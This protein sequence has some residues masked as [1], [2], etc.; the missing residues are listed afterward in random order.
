MATGLPEAEIARRLGAMVPTETP[1]VPG[2]VIL[3]PGQLLYSHEYN[4]AMTQVTWM[5][6]DKPSA[7]SDFYKVHKEHNRIPGHKSSEEHL[8]TVFEHVLPQLLRDDARMWIVGITDGAEN[9]IKYMD[10]KYVADCNATICNAVQAMAFMEPTHVAEMVQ[11]GIF[12]NELYAVGKCYIKSSKPK[13]EFLNAPG[14]A[15]PINHPS[16][17]DDN[18]VS[19]TS[20]E[21]IK[22]TE[23]TENE[24]PLAQ[25]D[26][27][28]PLAGSTAVLVSRAGNEMSEDHEVSDEDEELEGLLVGDGV[29]LPKPDASFESAPET[30]SATSLESH[31]HLTAGRPSLF[32]HTNRTRRVRR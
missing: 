12:K 22:P 27:E 3:N 25:G 32:C 4:T 10:A 15:N 1:V 2:L 26:T 16:Y 14:A 29:H 5:A 7:V 20:E 13:G 24:E 19:P 28:E 18:D 31:F 23:G 9:F 30:A 6:R 8:E 17:N 11:D 21:T